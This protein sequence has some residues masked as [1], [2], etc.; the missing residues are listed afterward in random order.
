M[1]IFRRELRAY[2]VSTI[3]WVVSF[4]VMVYMFLMIFTSFTKDIKD[5]QRLIVNLPAAVRAA[6]DISIK[7]FF[8]IYGFFA[9]LLSFISL[10]GAVQAMNLGVGIISK[11]DSGKTSDFLLTK[12]ISR[13]K[14]ITSKMLAA[15]SIILITN[16]IFN[17]SALIT[18]RI[19]VSG[20]LD[21]KLF[22][23]LSA[24]LLMVQ[25]FFLALGFL[26]AVILKKVKSV[27]AVSLPTVFTFFIIGALGAIIGDDKVRY[28]SP[29]KYFDSA[30]IIDHA[31]YEVNFLII[32][33]IFVIVAVSLSY[34]I[35]IKKDIKAA[36]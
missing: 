21:I 20:N 31:G 36:A 2:R 35:Y 19:V 11:E 18:A 12:P 24:T 8:T 14:V 7:N 6:F 23:L 27:V 26:M 3:I 5:S 29:F 10:T 15:L 25:M 1:N 34:L 33:T 22:L 30:Y 32:E 9:Y 4:A 16:I 28:L 13:S 17:I